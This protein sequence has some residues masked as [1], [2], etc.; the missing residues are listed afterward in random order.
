MKDAASIGDKDVERRVSISSAVHEDEK[1]QDAEF[2]GTEARKK[3][4]RKFLL[5]LDLRMSV[6]VVIYI[7]NY[8]GIPVPTLSHPET[9][10]SLQS[11]R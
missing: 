1:Y 10:T 6:L 4:E 2:G 3:L 11:D 7:L 5:K 8:V 9:L